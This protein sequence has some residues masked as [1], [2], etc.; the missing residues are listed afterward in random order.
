MVQPSFPCDPLTGFYV[1][2]GSQVSVHFGRCKP[3]ATGTL[4]PSAEGLTAYRY[5]NTL[6]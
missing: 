5:G 3:S 2:R 4:Q 6:N 1:I